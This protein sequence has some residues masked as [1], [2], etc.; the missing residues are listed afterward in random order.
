M[1]IDG[2][3]WVVTGA[4]GMLGRDLAEVVAEHGATVLGI[5]RADA[6]ITDLSS[7][8]V[9]VPE[10]DVIVNC[11]AYTAVDHAETDEEI[12]LAINGLGAG[13]VAAVAAAR[14]SRLVHVS[15]DYVFAGDASE[16]YA[17]DAS[18]APLSAYGR[19]KAAGEEAVEA[20]SADALIVR[21]AWLYGAHGVCFP[22]TI[23]KAGAE[24]GALT[25]VDDQIGQ[26]TWTRDLAAFIV[27]LLEV[28]APRGIYHGTSSGAGSWCD[29]AR[30]IVTVAG[31]GDIV[32]PTDSTA[33]VRPAPRPAWSVLGHDAST[34][35]GVAPIGDWRERWALA[36]PAVLAPH[37]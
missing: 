16:P 9:A 33:F 25:V 11:A 1:R 15:T 6:D 26:P 20:S 37:D 13:N 14:G 21:T 8:K 30:E 32:S 29:F 35:A 3:V 22:K 12:A 5:D 24:R 2:Q 31:L 23:A 17:E 34:A 7:L 19:T 4:H 36:A 27:A 18:R 10:C 28:D